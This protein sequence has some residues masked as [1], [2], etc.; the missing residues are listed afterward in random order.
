VCASYMHVLFL[1]FMFRP[2]FVTQTCQ[3]TQIPAMLIEL[4]ASI[5]AEVTCLR[6]NA[7]GSQQASTGGGQPTS[8]CLCL[9]RVQPATVTQP[10]KPTASQGGGTS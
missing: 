9:S 4:L 10:S 5:W 8:S 2:Q 6:A 7:A 1:M 3:L